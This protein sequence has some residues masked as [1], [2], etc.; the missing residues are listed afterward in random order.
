MLKRGT[1]LLGECR[2]DI[3][4]RERTI[5]VDGLREQRLNSYL[6]D[7]RTLYAWNQWGTDSNGMENGI[8]MSFNVW[9][10]V[11]FRL[12]YPQSAISANLFA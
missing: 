8:E 6:N 5:V 10:V 4:K 12:D 11:G 2:I 7:M 9:S 1:L 3:K